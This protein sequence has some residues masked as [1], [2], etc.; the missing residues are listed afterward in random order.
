[1]KMEQIDYQY[2]LKADEQY[3]ITISL[4]SSSKCQYK[5]N[6]ASQQEHFQALNVTDY[7]WLLEFS[8]CAQ[9]KKK[10]GRIAVTDNEAQISIENSQYFEPNQ[11]GI[12]YLNLTS[13]NSQNISNVSEKTLF[14]DN[15]SLSE[16]ATLL[17]FKKPNLSAGPI[18]IVAP[19]ADDAELA[20][21]GLYQDFAEQVW[22]TTINAG[23]NVQKLSQQYIKDLDSDMCDAV[24]RKAKIRAWNSRTTPLLAG[25]DYNHISY[26][27]YYNIT[28]T[29]LYETPHEVKL[30]TVIGQL[31]SQKER[32]FNHIN[33]PN[34]KNFINTGQALIDDLV[35]LIEQIKPSTIL[36]TDPEIDP[37]HEHI[38]AAH[39]VALAIQKSDYKPDNVLLYVNHLREIK[40]FPYG[41]EHARTALSPWYNSESV[42][43]E[44]SCYSHQL[45]M[46]TQKEK[47]VALDSM[48]DLRSKNRIEKNIK[49]WWSKKIIKSGYQFYSNHSYFQT[50]IKSN[51]VFAVI[52]AFEFSECLCK[53]R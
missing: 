38:V 9:H 18:L 44:Y 39:A 23:Q 14:C 49:Q 30:D 13:E 50:H 4:E 31:N 3:D 16:T 17:A 2:A 12:R 40:K 32:S 46:N 15:C 28:Q 21:Y 53:E 33:L 47:V 41:P 27:G 51:E 26:L 52:D 11:Q 34:D 25:V 35:S 22:I 37:H 5:L 45:S 24:E 43:G 48:H 19:H 10:Q 29:C 20:A 36:V 6:I 7:T 8:Y 1:M 42:F